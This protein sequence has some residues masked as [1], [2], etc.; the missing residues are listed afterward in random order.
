M[1]DIHFLSPL[2]VKQM[3]K[4]PEKIKTLLYSLCLAGSPACPCG[5][6]QETAKHIMLDCP[7]FRREQQQLR[8]A[9]STT[10]FQ[11]LT[12]NPRTAA[13]VTTWFLRLSLLSQFSRA[14]D[15]LPPA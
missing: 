11:Q 13:V 2:L 5:W 4:Q 14:R 12:S 7:R 15:Q 6:Q 1:N 10:D 8:Q 9:T 3:T